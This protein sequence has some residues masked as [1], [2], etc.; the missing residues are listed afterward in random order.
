MAVVIERNRRVTNPGYTPGTSVAPPVPGRGRTVSGLPFYS[1]PGYH[2]KMFIATDAGAKVTIPLAPQAVAHDGFGP[3]F[4]LLPRPGR[5]PLVVSDGPAARTYSYTI[6]VLSTADPEASVEAVLEALEL[7]RA[8]GARCTVSL[9]RLEQGLW[10]MS[11]LTINS[12]ARQHFTNAITHASVSMGF[13]EVLDPVVAVGPLTGGAVVAPQVPAPA[14]PAAVA[15]PS[16]ERY[17]VKRGD[18]LSGIAVRFYGRADRYRE[19]AAASGV[20]DPNKITPGQVLTIP[21]P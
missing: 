11:A 13:T 14:T 16:P 7:I 15:A 9:S 5:K 19:I 12:V 1:P 3:E 21:R 6:D 20:R 8:S 10:R 2:P 17:T 4:T 18:T